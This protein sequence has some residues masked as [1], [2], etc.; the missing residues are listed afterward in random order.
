[1]ILHLC[2]YFFFNVEQC[3]SA[4]STLK[5]NLIERALQSFSVQFPE[6][7]T[8][9]RLVRLSSF[10]L[11][12]SQAAVIWN[13]CTVLKKRER[14]EKKCEKNRKK[15]ERERRGDECYKAEHKAKVPVAN[16]SSEISLAVI[17]FSVL[18]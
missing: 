10:L 15:R 3:C 17:G 13:V 18:L 1:M 2:Y 11:S 4:A 14:K 5:L 12:L 16:F 8:C 7:S 6:D 9:S